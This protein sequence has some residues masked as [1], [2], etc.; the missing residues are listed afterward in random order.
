MLMVMLMLMNLGFMGRMHVL[1][2]AVFLSEVIMLMDVRI[3]PVAMRM[4]ML[5]HVLM[6]VNMRVLMRVHLVRMAMFMGVFMIMQVSMLMVAFHSASFS[7]EQKCL[8]GVYSIKI[9][10]AGLLSTPGMSPEGMHSPGHAGLKMFFA[11]QII[12]IQIISFTQQDYTD[13]YPKH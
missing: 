1:M 11:C 7:D 8:P 13:L 6:F 12:Q 9:N 2:G 3:L 4:T 5:M 10:P